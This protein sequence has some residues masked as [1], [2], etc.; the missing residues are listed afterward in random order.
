MEFFLEFSDKATKIVYDSSY[1]PVYFIHKT[2]HVLT[3]L[4]LNRNEVG[5]ISKSSKVLDTYEFNIPQEISGH[6]LVLSYFASNF[7]YI[8]KPRILVGGNTKS[9]NFSIRKGTKKVATTSSVLLKNGPH[10]SIQ[11]NGDKNI[12]LIILLI[13]LFD[14]FGFLGDKHRKQSFNKKSKIKIAYNNICGTKKDS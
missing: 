6:F 7:I 4:D 11:I 12:Q 8:P 13:E 9:F 5:R 14:Q 10:I 3:L 2:D 1:K